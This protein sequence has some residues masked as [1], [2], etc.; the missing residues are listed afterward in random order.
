MR[1][2]DIL[3]KLR[4][5]GPTKLGSNRLVPIPLGSFCTESE[6]LGNILKLGSFFAEMLVF[7]AKHK[8]DCTSILFLF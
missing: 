7:G 6:G 4:N 8:I 3:W 5:Q 1:F 2:S